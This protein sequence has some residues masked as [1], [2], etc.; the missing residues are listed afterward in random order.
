[1]RQVA[2]QLSV[3]P[4][5]ISKA[6]SQLELLGV[7]ERKPGVGMLVKASGANDKELRIKLL[8]PAID[9]LLLHAAQLNLSVD[10]VVENLNRRKEK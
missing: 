3:N 6:Y 10:E 5:T 2:R 1:M 4:M 8:E 9:E 7:V